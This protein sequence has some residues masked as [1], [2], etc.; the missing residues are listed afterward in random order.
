MAHAWKA[1]I[2]LNLSRVRIPFLP[3][4]KNK[5]MKIV[6]LLNQDIH[7]LKALNLLLNDLKKHQIQIVL[8]KKVGKNNSE[9]KKLN[10]LKKY[11]QEELIKISKENEEQNKFAKFLTFNQIAKILNSEIITFDNINSKESLQ[12]IQEFAPNLIISIRFGQILKN[13]LI[14]IPNQ[15]VINLHS[16]ILPNYRGV[17]ATFFAILQNNQEIGATLHYID[18]EKIDK[19]KIIAI[20]RQKVA[21]NHSLIYNIFMI[22]DEA[23]KNIQDFLNNKTKEFLPS[24]NQKEQYFSFP[25]IN[26]INEF[27]EKM[28]IIKNSDIQE[29]YQNFK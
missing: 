21:K 16:G 25:S 28:P 27:E 18:D 5:T 3:P 29:I 19:G 15:G 11:E 26:E 1:C 12:K 4:D 20:S 10:L 6:L 14:K 13:D 22:Y 17:L 2:G 7:A 24:K 23:V 9:N 8:S